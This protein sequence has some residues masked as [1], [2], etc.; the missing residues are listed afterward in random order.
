MLAHYCIAGEG[1]G[2]RAGTHTSTCRRFEQRGRPGG[3][4]L[5]LQ[6]AAEATSSAQTT[7]APLLPASFRLVGGEV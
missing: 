1:G 5:S 3:Q 7:R 4:V 6:K 2:R